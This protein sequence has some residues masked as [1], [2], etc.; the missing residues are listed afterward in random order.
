MDMKNKFIWS[1]EP[2]QT[3]FPVAKAG[4]SFIFAAAFTT[5]VFALL[6]LTTPALIGLLVTFSICLF[7]RD[8]DRVIP[9]DQN[10]IVSPADGKIVFAGH[11]EKSP[12]LDGPCMKISIFMSVFNVH[13][14]RVPHEG[15]VKNILYNPGKF[16]NA[17]FD[18]A[19]RDNEQ[20]AVLVETTDGRT[21]CF[22]QIAG[23]IAR[24][25]I[26]NIQSGDQVKRGQRMG[27]IC[28]GS[29]VDIY[30]PDQTRLNVAKGNKVK[31]GSTV[32]GYIAGTA[33]S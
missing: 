29:R 12:Y 24:R 15:I 1:D 31:G 20:N 17:S 7:F 11:E 25:I 13:I 4:Y 2:G 21:I 27:L 19:S 5:A 18:K 14:N 10:A 23:L 30:L 8:P 6:G 33:N 22:V 32:L 28:F 16:F 26:C 9:A 3:A